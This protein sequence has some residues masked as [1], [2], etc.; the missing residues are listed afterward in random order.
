MFSGLVEEMGE[1]VA[2]DRSGDAPS[3]ERQ[4]TLRLRVAATTVTE[5]ARIGDSISHNGCCLTVIDLAPDHSWY[6]VEAV[7]ETLR[8]TSLGSLHVG[9]RVNL[10]RP[11]RADGR[12][13]GHIVQG[14]VDATATVLHPAPALRVGVPSEQMRYI[15]EKG[16]IT[17]DGVSLTVASLGPDWVEVALI[18]HTAAVTTLGSRQPGDTVNVEFDVIAKYVERLL[19]PLA[20]A[21]AKEAE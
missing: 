10:E 7:E 18:P 17:L 12:F 1:I 9:D 21:D 11:L 13:G 2:V 8:R 3:S 6:A 19:G 20:G 14:H 4:S 15:A 5:G 16:S